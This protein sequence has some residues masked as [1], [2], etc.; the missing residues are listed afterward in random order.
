MKKI[1]N[2][3]LFFI[4][5]NGYSQTDHSD[6]WEDFFSYNNVKDIVASGDVIYALSDNAIFTYDTATEEVEKISSVNGLSGQETSA[7]FYSTST[8]RLV[9]GYDNGLLE[10]VDDSGSITIAPDIVNFNQTG[11]KSINSIFEFNSKLYL[12]T[13]FAIIVYDIENLE[14][15]DTFFIGEGSSDVFINQITVLGDEIYAATSNG[16][17]VAD[18][19]ATNLIDA[20]NWDLRFIGD[21]QNIIAYNNAVYAIENETVFRIDGASRVSVLSPSEDIK[22]IKVSEDNLILSLE[23]S[24]LIYDASLNQIGKNGNVSDFNFTLNTAII[25]DGSILLGTEEFGLLKGTISGGEYEEIHPEGPLSNDIFSVDTFDNNLWIVYGGYTGTFTPIAKRQGFTH[26]NGETWI[27]VVSDENNLLVDLVNVTIDETADNRVFISSFADTREVNTTLTGGLY[28]VENDEIKIFYNHLNSPLEDV[29]ANDPDRVTVRISETVFDDEG[30]L[31]VTNIEVEN[32]LKRLSN[33]GVWTSFNLS[34]IVANEGTP[35]IA[36]IEIDNRGSKWMATRGNGVL[37]FNEEGNQQR[38]IITEVNRG[39]LPNMRVETVAIDDS[40]DVWIGTRSGLVV[41]DNAGS[42]FDSDDYNAEPVI[43]LQNGLAERLLGDQNIRTIAVDGANNKWFGTDS[44][45]ALNTNGNGQTT[46]ANFNTE[47]SPLPSDR[48]L[49]ISIDDSTG[50]VFFVTDK[51]LVAFNS[52]VAPFADELMEVYAYP[53]PVLKN[54]DI[55]TIAGRNG[56]N[57]PENTNVKILD[58]SGHLVYE[59]NTIEGEQLQGGKVVWD[60]RNL[61]GKKVA[62]GI[63][64]VLLATADGTESMTTKIAIVN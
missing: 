13:A 49:K 18:V 58:I 11:L 19:R 59:T 10:I 44:G 43:I 50:K 48:I 31:W 61:A 46:L 25:N 30:D 54:H 12:S 57:L 26:F 5:F 51:G 7:I 52:N 14:F 33:A 39:S 62:S 63:Y 35:G 37:I 22:D 15:G 8:E 34:S 64:I 20:A 27:D 21:Y 6:L 55:V 24:A 36:E 29:V 56:T 42:I 2:I 45:G 38:A 60:K 40:N 23:D 4:A 16:I 1:I 9:I 32:M 53:N 3:L 47:N 41:F 17:Y 28:E